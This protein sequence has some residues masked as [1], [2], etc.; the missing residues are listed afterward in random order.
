MHEWVTGDH[1]FARREWKGGTP[2]WVVFLSTA[3]FASIMAFVWIRFFIPENEMD[4]A[5]ALLRLPE[6]DQGRVILGAVFVIVV[7]LCMTFA[8]WREGRG[9]PGDLL[10][11]NPD[12]FDLDLRYGPDYRDSEGD[13]HQR[14]ISAIVFTPDVHRTVTLPLLRDDGLFTRVRFTIDQG[15]IRCDGDDGTES[16]EGDYGLDDGITMKRSIAVVS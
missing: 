3:V 7:T 5:I 6:G 14:R 8:M 10:G 16:R 4:R 12:D 9:M 11:V 1:E 2:L 15:Q 13:T